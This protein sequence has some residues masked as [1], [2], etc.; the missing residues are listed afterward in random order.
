[1]THF[2]YFMSLPMMYYQDLKAKGCSR[3]TH[4]LEMIPLFNITRYITGKIFVGKVLT[5]F[6]F[7]RLSS[8]KLSSLL[9][10]SKT[11]IRIQKLY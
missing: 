8:V 5:N 4:Y 10:Y 7:H 3:T 11:Q 6:P 1:M 2:K 9:N